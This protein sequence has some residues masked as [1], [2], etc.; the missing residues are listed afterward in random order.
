MHWQGELAESLEQHLLEPLTKTDTNRFLSKAGVANQETCDYIYNLTN[1]LPFFLDICVDLY[2]TYKRDHNGAEPDVS[3]FGKKREDVVERFFRYM[4]DVTR[5]MIKFLCGLGRW[6]DKLAFEI[7]TK[8]FNFSQTTY[9]RV[10]TLS[11]IKSEDFVIDDMRVENFSTTIFS[12]DRTIQNILFPSCNKNVLEK[13]LEVADEYF[14]KVLD[15]LD[16][17]GKYLF[18]LEYW[19]K[20]TMRLTTDPDDLRKRYEKNFENRL[21]ILIN[22]RCLFDIAE[23]ILKIFV[24]EFTDVKGKFKDFQNSVAF[25]Y[26][27]G[28][29]G[30]LKNAQGLYQEALAYHKNSYEK[31][32]NLLGEEKED[33]IS[34]MNN[35]ALTLN[36]LGRNDEALELQHKAFDLYKKNLG[37]DHPYTITAMNNLALTL[38]DFGRYDEAL[39]LQQQALDLCKKILGDDHPNTI[40]SMNNL[41]LTLRDLG[42]YDEA[43]ELQQQAL[44]LYKKI[45]GDEHPDT[46][47]VMHEFAVTLRNFGRN[48]EALELQQ[49]ALDLYKK[50]LGD[51]HPDTIRA[52]DSLSDILSALGRDDEALALKEKVLDFRKN[53][54]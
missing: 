38:G 29:F 49:Q 6:T 42:R 22:V 16:M 50:I 44:D 41:A 7:G 5:D 8:T 28:Q 14:S 31:F 1:G 3:I 19:A 34:A 45:L 35:L 48:E 32:L 12:F 46:I 27:E 20:L 21:S 43:L 24:E 13:T 11:S 25:A 37:D 53:N 15:E 17:I 30:K 47:T 40:M 9:D 18:N 39:E 36:Y 54:A 23:N 10:K 51:E 4:D 26:F 2:A 52:M 33:T